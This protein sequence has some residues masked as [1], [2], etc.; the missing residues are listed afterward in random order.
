MDRLEI[1]RQLQRH[2]QQTSRN[3]Q[4]KQLLFYK[5]NTNNTHVFI[6]TL[7]ML[8]LAISGGFIS[9][10]LGCGTQKVFENMTTKHIILFS[11]IYFTLDIS[12][13]SDGEPLHPIAQFKQSIFLY[14]G[15]LL[16]TKMNFYFTMGAF[17]LLCT[18]YILGNHSK[19]LNWHITRLKNKK[20]K[21]TAEEGK[22]SEY[23]ILDNQ[24]KSYQKYANYAIGSVLIIGCFS[25]LIIKKKE[26]GSRFSYITFFQ[27]VTKC[28]SL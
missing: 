22:L 25:Y 18:S 19:H 11:L 3:K 2:E 14:I 1:E 6:K 8:L 21:D 5:F 24:S 28:D 12:D 17:A 26:Y 7:F 13:D 20:K 4:Q 15:F 10:T 9:K 23:E 27:G 16:F